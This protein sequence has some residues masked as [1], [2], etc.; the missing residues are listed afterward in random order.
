[1]ITMHFA[2]SQ[3]ISFGDEGFVGTFGLLA[4]LSIVWTLFVT[5]FWM[6]VG[7]RAMRA[8]ER[9]ARSIETIART[10]PQAGERY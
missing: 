9:A 8:H 3:T 10:R 4:F 5:V 6:F 2:Q 1:M 7:W